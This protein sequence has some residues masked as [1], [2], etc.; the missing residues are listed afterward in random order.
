MLMMIGDYDGCPIS[1]DFEFIGLSDIVMEGKVGT[2]LSLAKNIM[3]RKYLNDI[4]ST[5]AGTSGLSSW[6]VETH[7]QAERSVRDLK[8]KQKCQNIR[9]KPCKK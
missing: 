9:A 6:K 2:V 5:L 1:Y 4:T 7:A 8:L 3:D